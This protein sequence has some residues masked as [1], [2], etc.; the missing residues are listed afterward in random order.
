MAVGRIFKGGARS[1]TTTR[2]TAMLPRARTPWPPLPRAGGGYAPATSGEMTLRFQS[3]GTDRQFF[4]FVPMIAR[5][6]DD[7]SLKIIGNT[8][9]EMTPLGGLFPDYLQR[10][11]SGRSRQ[12]RRSCPIPRRIR[13]AYSCGSTPP[14]LWAKAFSPPGS[15][16]C[17]TS[18]KLTQRSLW[19]RLCRRS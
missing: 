19:D 11:V 12:N 9:L 13:R 6:G 2:H 18:L 4:A 8:R 17:L 1:N 15:P 14:R 16:Y 10:L 7:T 3:R 5:P